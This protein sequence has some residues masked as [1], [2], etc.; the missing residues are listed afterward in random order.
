RSIDEGLAGSRFGIVVIGPYFF[1]KEWPQR[2]LDALVDREIGDRTRVVLPVWHNITA[3]DVRQ[4]SPTFA[5]RVAVLSTKGLEHVVDELLLGMGLVGRRESNALEYLRDKDSELGPAIRDMVW[6]SAWGKW[7]MAQ[8]FVNSG[9]AAEEE[10]EGL[11]AAS[12]L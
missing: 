6:R 7:Y 1:A 9:R 5:D 10:E 11:H 12:L 3:A 2:E 8:L 4:H